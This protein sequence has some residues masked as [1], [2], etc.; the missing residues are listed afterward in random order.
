MLRI[1]LSL[2]G[3]KRSKLFTIDVI[4]SKKHRNAVPID[5]IGYIDRKQNKF[6]IDKIKYKKYI[7]VGANIKNKKLEKFINSNIK[8]IKS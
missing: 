6:F 4:D 2:K 7:S 8:N 5:R 1:R 3:N